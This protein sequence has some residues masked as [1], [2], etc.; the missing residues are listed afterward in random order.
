MTD[1]DRP[2]SLA[3]RLAAATRIVAFED[4]GD[5]AAFLRAYFRASGYDV[6]HVDPK[7]PAEVTAAVVEH[8]PDCVLL[9]YNLRGFSGHD[10]YELI[11]TDERFAFTPVIV[12]SADVTAGRQ[13]AGLESGID[14]FVSK[15]FN[16]N[17]LAELIA[18]RIAAARAVASVGRDET[19]GLFTH[20]Y[21]AA[22]IADEL[23]ASPD[24][25]PLSFALVQV[26]NLEA[27]HR[28]VDDDGLTFVMREL[29]GH[30]R[31]RLPL[32]TVLGRTETDELAVLVPGRTPAELVPTL[33]IVLD[34]VRGHL[35]LP[36][37]AGLR[38]QVA[39][40]VAGYPDH[41]SGAEE[42]YMAADAALADARDAGDRLRIAI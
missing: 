24:L 29:I 21:L 4:D 12:V 33:D 40:G 37:G 9:D 6:I 31:D 38:V 35:H 14:G 30:A 25:E 41:A 3:N 23:A 27:N 5:I 36:G 10:A 13:A 1:P 42:L 39:A 34:E 11:R 8:R 32:R 2:G 17:S 22:R 26:R 18:E 16:V 28:A 7:G 15:P 20:R 19:Y